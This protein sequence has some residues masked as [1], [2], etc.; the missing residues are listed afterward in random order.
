MRKMEK[1]RKYLR[2]S[3]YSALLTLSLYRAGICIKI[4][5]I[6]GFVFRRIEEISLKI[7]FVQ[8]DGLFL[9]SP[10]D[11]MIESPG[12]MNTRFPSHE[13]L[14]PRPTCPLNT[15]LSLPNPVLTG[16]AF[17]PQGHTGSWQPGWGIRPGITGFRCHRCILWPSRQQSS[18]FSDSDYCPDSS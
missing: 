8:E 15:L 10:G 2:F 3:Y 5:G 16:F 14:V 17:S 12:E 18:A 7:C 13:N 6:S 1:S 9:I 11:H 4:E